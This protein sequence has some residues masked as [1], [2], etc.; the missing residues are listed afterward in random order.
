[1]KALSSIDISNEGSLYTFLLPPSFVLGE[2]LSLCT[3]ETFASALNIA[4][5]YL[6]RHD[7]LSNRLI[8]DDI[9]GKL[10]KAFDEEKELQKTQLTQQFKKEL[11]RLELS[12]EQ[13]KKE[14]MKHIQELELLLDGSRVSQ[15]ILRKQFLDETERRI[16]QK[17]SDLHLLIQQLRS[18]IDRERA[19]KKDLSMQLSA[20]QYVSSNSS[21]KG[22]EGE[23]R[24]QTL[25][26]ERKGWALLDT[27]KEG[28]SG[29]FTL[30][31]YTMN[32]RFEIKEYTTTVPGKEAEKFRRDLREH[33]ET[34]IG[35]FISMNT[36]ITSINGLTIEWTPKHQLILFIPN[37]LQYDM[38]SI[39]QFVDIVFQSMKPYYTLLSKEANHNQ[40]PE[41]KERI[42]RCLLLI[43]NSIKHI[44]DTMMVLETDRRALQDRMDTM[45]SN[46]RRSL[47]S[48][49]EELN[50]V[51]SILTD[52]VES[53]NQPTKE[54]KPKKGRAVK[55]KDTVDEEH[56]EEK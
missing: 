10:Q 41:L 35:V 32:T 52:Q 22:K 9:N 18:D 45:H 11:S 30:P 2:H 23:L 24:F 31:I 43:Q 20:K 50:T 37:F 48:Q 28:H 29:D 53:T 39:F 56:N 17:E 42:D 15:D 16:Q 33:P 46:M 47:V 36:P 55:K 19:E 13:E 27:S 6:K 40:Y 25:A 51:V 54:Q 12:L 5:E 44:V 34:T 1:M 14:S 4:E 8:S 38:D 26:F 21:K 7:I 49:K 3:P